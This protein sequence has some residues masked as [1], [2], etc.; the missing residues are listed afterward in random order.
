[1]G[2]SVKVMVFSLANFSLLHGGIMCSEN[3]LKSIK[4]ALDVDITLVTGGEADVEAGNNRFANE[5]GLRHRF[6]KLREETA[7][8]TKSAQVGM[9]ITLKELVAVL[10]EKYFYFW[11]QFS[12]KHAYLDQEVAKIAE[13]ERPNLIILDGIL[14]ALCAPST[15]LLGTPCCFVTHNHEVDIHRDFKLQGNPWGF[16]L[17][18]NALRWLAARLN[19]IPNLRFGRS[20][21]RLYKSCAGIIA[22]IPGDLPNNLPAQVR[23]V[24]L[25]PLLEER[26]RRW[27]YQGRR[28]VLYVGN[29]GYFANRLAVEWICSRLAPELL[30][31]DQTVQVNIIGARPDDV[32]MEWRLKNINFLGYASKDE[33]VQ[34]MLSDDLFIAPTS[35]TYGAKLK[36]AEC[37]SHGMPFA[38]SN[39]AMGGLPFLTFI[40]NL[41]LSQPAVAAQ[42]VVECLNDTKRL[43]TLSRDVTRVMQEQRVQQL[44]DLRAFIEDLMAQQHSPESLR[45]TAAHLAQSETA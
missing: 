13:E 9:S 39:T 41:D 11:E 5:M 10:E 24:V 40:P 44:I 8:P 23:T 26:S 3:L 42:V 18:S 19:W 32:P 6:L 14:S 31:A 17:N 28:S 33:V 43:T 38:A 27:A 25:P 36:L 21:E 34:H 1:M 22:L 15:F 45:S 20:V 37:A 12:R 29:V 30:R 4:R 35:Q 7:A 16:C 2:A